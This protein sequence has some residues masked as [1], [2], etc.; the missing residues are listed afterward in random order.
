VDK[1]E[2]EKQELNMGACLEE[3]C[4]ILSTLCE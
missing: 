3:F 4:M 2:M 1:Q